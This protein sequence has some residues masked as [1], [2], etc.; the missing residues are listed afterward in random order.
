M[1]TPKSF[2][3]AFPFAALS[4][5]LVGSPTIA[6]PA[7]QREQ[8]RF[9]P[10]LSLKWPGKASES[11]QILS[12][13]DGDEKHYTALFSKKGTAG[14]VIFSAFVIE[15]PDKALKSTT[16][17][18]LLAA[19][20]FSSKDDETSR[21]EVEH[22]PKKYPGLEIST[23]ARGLFGRK[24]VVMAGSRLYEVSVSSKSEEALKAPEVKTFL[25]SLALGK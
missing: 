13:E 25:E 21:K 24:L 20:V 8:L 22:G 18:T 7:A 9:Q 16:A 11:S 23:H 3:W 12:T 4:G 17:K 5:L 14:V 6:Q 15:F 19:Y 2:L 10:N 1:L